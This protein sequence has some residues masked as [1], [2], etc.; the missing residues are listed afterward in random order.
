MTEREY[1]RKLKIIKN[2][3]IQ[4]E[5][6]ESL[7]KEK[8]KYKKKTHVETHKALAVYLF[9]LINVII[10]YT[11]A[12]M[13]IFQD[14]SLLD[15]LITSVVSE[16][17]V[18]AIYCIKAYKGKKQEEQMKLEYSKLSRN[19]YLNEDDNYC[20]QLYSENN[21]YDEEVEL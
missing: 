18:F 2:K 20:E 21:S 16:V 11:L 17:I 8:N 1:Q 12:A 6:R 3:N 14:I 5:Y 10:T 9:I 15:V 7:R 13:W 4:R 19:D